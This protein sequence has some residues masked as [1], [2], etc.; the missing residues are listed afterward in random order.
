MLNTAVEEIYAQE[1]FSILNSCPCCHS[2][3]IH[4]VGHAP[5]IHPQSRLNVDILKCQQCGHWFTKQMPSSEFL[6]SL[7]S[8]VSLTVV[9]EGWDSLT[10]DGDRQGLTAPDWHWVVLA[11][12]KQPPGVMLEVGPGNGSL[13]RKFRE[14]GW[15][16]YGIDPGNWS[17][18]SSIYKHVNDLPPDVMFDAIVFE[19][20]LEH[21]SNPWQEITAY[22]KYLKPNCDLFMTFPWSE[23]AEAKILGSQ[24]NMVR[25]LGHL[26]YFSKLSARRLAESINMSV[27]NVDVISYDPRTRK[28]KIKELLS[29]LREISALVLQRKSSSDIQD[30][31]KHLMTMWRSSGD[32]LYVRARSGR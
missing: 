17:D 6:A 10:R 2:E 32:Q 26:H 20:V 18:D 4:F 29:G 22:Q 15:Q 7:Y 3:S 9:G 1:N 8:N 23:S 31:Y 27:L 5:T 11:L 30:R 13:M 21:C 24:W 28:T 14:L 25:P 12:A 16:V 19:D